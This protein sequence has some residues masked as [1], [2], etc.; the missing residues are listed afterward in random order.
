MKKLLLAIIILVAASA[1]TQDSEIERPIDPIDP[2]SLDYANLPETEFKHFNLELMR[3][4]YPL[5]YRNEYKIQSDARYVVRQD[6]AFIALWDSVGNAV[7]KTIADYSGVEWVED[8]IDIHPVRYLP[9]MGLYSPMVMPWEGIKTRDYTEAAPTG[10]RRFL[11]LIRLFCGRNLKQINYP[12]C[13]WY[14][15]NDHPLLQQSAYRFD[16]ITMTLTLTVAP[17]FIH[18]DTLNTIVSSDSWQRSFD[19]WTVFDDYF[20]NNWN[21]STDSVLAQFLSDESYNSPLVEL[22][23]PPRQVRVEQETA[24][25]KDRIKMGAGKGRLGFSVFKTERGLF[26]VVD[27]DSTKIAYAS[28]LM[29]ADLIKRVNGE[30][31]RTTRELMGMILDKIDEEGVYMIVIRDGEEQGLLLLPPSDF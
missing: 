5:Y 13:S 1:F 31:V 11:N 10:M 21:I 30:V 26:E 2:Y 27:V 19:G 22:S 20:R 16:N 24:S 15:L 18:P 25:Q 8:N 3:T 23:R 7:M 17:Y 28:G 4:F 9:S 6:S 12:E 14:Y 29:P